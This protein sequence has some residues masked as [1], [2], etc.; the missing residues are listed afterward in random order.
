VPI[1]LPLRMSRRAVVRLLIALTLMF[2]LAPVAAV[3]AQPAHAAVGDG[4]YTWSR[5]PL[6]SGMSGADVTQL[7]IRIAGWMAYGE[8]LSI[9][10]SFGPKTEAAV[11]RFQAGYGL[12]VDGVAGP[13]TLGKIVE[14]QKDDCSPAHFAWSE[15][16]GGCGQGGFSGGALP[17]DQI[18]ENLKRAMWKAE[19]MRHK[20]GDRPINASGF[21]SYSCNNSIPNADPNSQHLYGRALDLTATW[22]T[23]TGGLCD[24]ARAARYAGYNGILGPGY[25]YHNDHVH[26]DSRSSRSWAA[27]TCGI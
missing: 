24:I 7:Q 8:V 20:L 23:V 25:Q 4:C 3:V 15:V 22:G 5:V 14:L 1:N 10:G 27:P 17:P 11:R 13:Q 18:K 9:D 2:S 6:S 16:D 21:R 19:A 12:S 26:V